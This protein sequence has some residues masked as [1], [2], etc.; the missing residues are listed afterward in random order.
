MKHIILLHGFLSS[1]KSSKAT[2]LHEK[3]EAMPNVHFH[4]FD[5]NPTPKDFEYMTTSGMINRLRQHILDRKIEACT[6][7]G[8]S[9]GGLVALNYAHRFGGVT[10]L[11]LM[12]PLLAYFEGSR[13]NE[14]AVSADPAT[15]ERVQHFGFDRLLPL[16]AEI[17][18]DGLLYKNRVPPAAP[19]TIVHGRFDDI[20][21]IRQSQTYAAQYPKQV[22]LLE[23]DSDHRL[24][25]QHELMWKMIQ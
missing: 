22:Q 24:S 9:M 20:I 3:F 16:R 6:L 7:V 13:D 19:T 8:S 14:T 4:S 17:D 10:Q 23:V 2:F 15:V 18:S 25:D 5:F 1:G 11:V 21:F 12:A